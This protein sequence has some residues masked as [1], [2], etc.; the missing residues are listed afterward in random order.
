MKELLSK[1]NYFYKISNNLNKIIIRDGGKLKYPAFSNSYDDFY[2]LSRSGHF[3]RGISSEE[4][5][6]IQS[7]GYVQSDRRYCVPGEGTCFSRSIDEAESYINSSGNDPRISNKSN[8][9]IEVKSEA[10][11][12]DKRDDYYKTLDD[13]VQIPISDIK[14]V[15]ELKPIEDKI[16]A[17]QIL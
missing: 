2:N 10:L 3:Y 9:V 11:K 14:R 6:F 5:N 16:V 15:W 13:N 7:K 8:Y 4:W 1:I 17:I 12:H